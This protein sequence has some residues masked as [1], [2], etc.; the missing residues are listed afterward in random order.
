[1]VSTQSEKIFEKLGALLNSPSTTTNIW[2]ISE[3]LYV[4]YEKV[5]NDI[6]KHI[7]QLAA[8]FEQLKSVLFRMRLLKSEF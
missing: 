4:R 8:L 1:M 7:D 3:L 6:T 5:K 2:K